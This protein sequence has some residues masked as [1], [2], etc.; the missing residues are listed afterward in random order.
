M[1]VK[2]KRLR[3][4]NTNLEDL[5]KRQSSIIGELKNQCLEV[6]ER[7]EEANKKWKEERDSLKK[8]VTCLELTLR[9]QSDKNKDIETQ[10]VQHSK[11]YERLIK[12]FEDPEFDLRKKYR[13]SSEEKGRSGLAGKEIK[14]SVRKMSPKYAAAITIER[15]NAVKDVYYP[16]RK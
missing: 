7:F 11:L 15:D 3:Q 4:E 14:G 13:K 9:E 8:D 10:Y 16:K 12:R 5:L 6:T 1:R 2:E